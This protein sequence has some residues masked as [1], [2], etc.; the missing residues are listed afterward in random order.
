MSISMKRNGILILSIVTTGM[1]LFL[2]PQVTA[3]DVF[4]EEAC[5]GDTS[6]CKSADNT[7]LFEII[8]TV[9]NIM[10]FIAGIIAVIM[11]IV[12][13]IKY[14]TSGGDSAGIT[15]AKNTILY[16]VVGLAVAIMS[17]AIVN[18]VL[19]RFS[20]VDM[21]GGGDGAGTTEQSDTTDGSGDTTT[22]SGSAGSGSGSGGTTTPSGGAGSGSG[23]GG[24]TP[25]PTP[26]PA[27]APT[28]PRPRWNLF[29]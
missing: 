17:F 22:P 6:I 8:K 26:N 12:G 11:I 14:A 21:G 18:F 20:K 2:T 25:N 29:Q 9:I 7:T 5:N 10:I 16:A 3:I 4:R 27:P 23:S 24:T 19:D 28:T 1:F 13:G 15:S